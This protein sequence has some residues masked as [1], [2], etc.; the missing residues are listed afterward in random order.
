[1][2]FSI[3]FDYLK[4]VFNIFYLN[5]SFHSKKVYF[6]ISAFSQASVET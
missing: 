1:M 6:L 2:N 5:I 4:F 3:F